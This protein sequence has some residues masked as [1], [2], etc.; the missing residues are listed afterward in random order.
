MARRPT[1]DPAV[2][3]FLRVLRGERDAS[4]HTV[5]AY[6]SDLAAFR[7]H[8]EGRL[9]AGQKFSWRE[10]DRF[11]VRGFL[12]HLQ[13]RGCSRTTLQRKMSSLRSFFRYLE[14]EGVVRESPVGRMVLPTKRRRLPSVLSARDVAR[15]LEA[16]AACAL[17]ASEAARSDARRADAILLGARD[18]ALL[19]I[20]YS[21]GL[22]IQETVGLNDADV[23]LLGESLKVRGKRKK[24]RFAPVGR[25]AAEALEAYLEARTGRFGPR[26]RGPLFV[27]RAGGRLTARSVER[28]FK[29]YLVEVGL[30]PAL[31]PHALRH[32][33]AT[34]LLDAGADLRS[35]QEL[36]GHANL[37]STQIYT[38]VTAER[39]KSVYDATHPRA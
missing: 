30:D 10:I 11:S 37:S 9:P 23:D 17:R 3:G 21:G 12:G 26:E 27:N 20:M 1:R 5:S 34:H 7:G 19:E 14:R 18:R 33:F 8:V 36:M 28:L 6:A 38:H 24:E 13:Q 39:L 25:P 4:S 16:P 35:V 2:E 32:S 22:R 31:S 29:K 15:L